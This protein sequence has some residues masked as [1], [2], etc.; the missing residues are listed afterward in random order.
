MNKDPELKGKEGCN[1]N[2]TA[3]Q[4]PG[5]LFFNCGTRAWYC[6]ECA[7][8]INEFALR[9]PEVVQGQC[10]AP[11]NQDEIDAAEAEMKN[12]DRNEAFKAIMK[13]FP[14]EDE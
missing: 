2:R 6:Y 1:C 13:Y 3:C 11:F 7:K 10:P 8:D 14:Y 9:T 12:L 5:A 4:Q